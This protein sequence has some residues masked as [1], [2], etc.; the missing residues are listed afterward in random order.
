MYA[1]LNFFELAVLQVALSSFQHLGPHR[2][3][4]SFEISVDDIFIKKRIYN[5]MRKMYFLEKKK[6]LN[7]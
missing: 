5:T 7:K 2:I 1:Y 3:Y 6:K 4:E